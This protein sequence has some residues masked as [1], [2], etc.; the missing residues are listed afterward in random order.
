MGGGDGVALYEG[1]K[2]AALSNGEALGPDTPLVV[3]S[4]WKRKR[5]GNHCIGGFGRHSCGGLR[6]RRAPI[7]AL[8]AHQHGQRDA[9]TGG[10][11][12]LKFDSS[13]AAHFGSGEKTA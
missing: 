2:T 9:Y 3:G 5:V 11:G 1:K 6:K 12:N 8:H 13:G 4:N 10:G 7:T